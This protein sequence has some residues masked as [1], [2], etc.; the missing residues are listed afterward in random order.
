MRQAFSTEEKSVQPKGQDCKERLVCWSNISFIAE[1]LGQEV[2]VKERIVHV[3]W[4]EITF[5]DDLFWRS[6]SLLFWSHDRS[7]FT[8]NNDLKL[9]ICQAKANKSKSHQLHPFAPP[10]AWAESTTRLGRIHQCYLLKTKQGFC[11]WLATPT[12]YQ[13]VG[14]C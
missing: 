11:R 7:T 14:M 1:L 5:T 4:S 6:L 13:C 9:S 10:L 8:V 2:A 3:R 12:C